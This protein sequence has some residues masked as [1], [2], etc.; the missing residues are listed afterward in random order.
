[1]LTAVNMP[2]FPWAASWTIGTV[3]IVASAIMLRAPGSPVPGAGHVDAATG[4]LDSATIA[5]PVVAARTNFA[6]HLLAMPHDLLNTSAVALF[7]HGALECC[8]A[9][10]KPG[11]R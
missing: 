11:V 2:A 6:N 5:A 8:P 7:P 10:A 3:N 4:A 9:Y 1:L